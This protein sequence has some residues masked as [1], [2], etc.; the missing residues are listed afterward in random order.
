M[1]NIQ[2]R[3][4]EKATIKC[5]AEADKLSKYI[6]TTFKTY[7]NVSTQVRFPGSDKLVNIARIAE[8]LASHYFKNSLERYKDEETKDFINRFK[9]LDEQFEELKEDFDCHEHDI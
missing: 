2:Y 5:R 1:K 8:T 9:E 7:S 6:L 3:L 4:D